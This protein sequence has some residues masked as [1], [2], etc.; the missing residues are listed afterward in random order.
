MDLRHLWYDFLHRL[1]ANPVVAPCSRAAKAALES[2]S[3]LP[4]SERMYMTRY[5]TGEQR[6]SGCVTSLVRESLE[7]KQL[8]RLAVGQKGW[9][10]A[11]TNKATVTYAI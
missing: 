10:E 2:M 4:Y 5:V 3:I 8:F 1:L 6:A 11:R 7:S 9:D